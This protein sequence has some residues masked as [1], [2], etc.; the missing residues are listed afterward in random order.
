MPKL[1]DAVFENG[2]FRPLSNI[3]AHEHERFKIIYYPSEEFDFLKMA[4]DGGS[5]DFLKDK[6]EDIYTASDGEEA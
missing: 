3:P 2:A 5:F 6:D 4:Q 1:V